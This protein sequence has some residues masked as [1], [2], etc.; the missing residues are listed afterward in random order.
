MKK[1]FFGDIR[2]NKKITFKIVILIIILNLTCT[3]CEQCCK[4]IEC[5]ECDSR[6]DSRCGESFNLTRETG[7]TIEC[8]E[9]CVKLKHFYNEGYHYMRT[10]SSTIK[11][12][13]IKKTQV[14][15]TTM[16]KDDGNLCFCEEDLCN[17][18]I[19]SKISSNFFVYFFPRF[20]FNYVTW[21]VQTIFTLFYFTG[22]GL[23]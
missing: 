14:C 17:R 22:L 10:C 16:S 21:I 19:S 3:V 12:I 23:L 15:Y 13:F 7:K 1:I 20:N 11:D 9:F 4:K 8:T 18:A 6:F 2:E 5:F